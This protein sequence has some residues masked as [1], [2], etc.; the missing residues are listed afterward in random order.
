[1]AADQFFATHIQEIGHPLMRVYAWQPR[2]ISL[3][4][5]QKAACLDLSACQEKGVD[6][7]R[8]P[9]GG[10]AVFHAE[11]V[12]YS[13][14]IPVD[15]L[16]NASSLTE[17]YQRLSEGLVH[18]LQ[19]LGVPAEFAKRH[20]DLRTHYVTQE[21]V[22]C[23]SAAALHEV[24]VRS[25]KIVGSAQRGSILTGP[26]HLEL[27]EYLSD[28]SPAVRRRIRLALQSKTT[29]VSQELNRSVS[30]A[31]IVQAI[32]RGMMK[33]LGI[34]F[35]NRGVSDG[36]KQEIEALQDGFSLLKTENQK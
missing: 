18:G 26:A 6:V 24:V 34:R 12:T 30:C 20:V 13:V 14:I 31:E 33:T 2:C 9:T 27:P 21:S 17:I 22:G 28:L 36:E 32:R 8:R 4:Y 7:V 11:E 1:M 3:G 25:R 15:R 23:F 29:S 35:E 16:S 5:H 10:R 19:L